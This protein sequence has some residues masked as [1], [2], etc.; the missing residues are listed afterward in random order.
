M[1]GNGAGTGTDLIQAQVRP[2][3]KDHH[4]AR[5]A[6]CVAAVGT[7]TPASAEL[8]IGATSI[9]RTAA[10]SSAS[11]SPVPLVKNER[12][13]PSGSKSASPSKR[14]GDRAKEKGEREEEEKEV[15]G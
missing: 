12:R 11:A 6:C 14:R 7:A 1:Y 4:Q 3:H 13:Y 9:P 15:D 10:A 2:I 5:A 8:P